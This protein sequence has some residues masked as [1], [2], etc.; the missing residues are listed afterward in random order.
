[1]NIIGHRGAKGYQPENTLASFQEAISLGVDMI[2]LDVYTIA[3]G[4]VVV[5][6]D[7]TVERTTNGVGSVADFT[8]DEL[9]KLDAGHG[10]TVPLLTEVLDLVDGRMP[11]NIEIKGEQSAAAVAEIV[12]DYVQRKGWR[13][14]LF[15]VSSFNLQE[16]H[17]FARLS[18]STPISPLFDHAEA[19]Q[20]QAEIHRAIV[21]IG[22]DALS[23]TLE[24]V[25]EA[26]RHG[27]KVYA[28]TVNTQLEADR[29]RELQVDGVFSDYPD[30]VLGPQ[31][32]HRKLAITRNALQAPQV[33]L[34]SSVGI[35]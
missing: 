1:M 34:G 28:Y 10:Q 17:E 21:S 3:S 6:H 29:M 19:S 2:E 25:R 16:L 13:H 11:V 26:H 32:T 33:Q 8:F 24:S 31:Y 30:R 4:E 14:D 18:P 20:L 22:I 23:V 5:I 35:A 27:V 15:L 9:R 7:P 12:D